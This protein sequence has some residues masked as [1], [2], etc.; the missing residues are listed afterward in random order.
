MGK[1]K[2]KHEATSVTFFSTKT[3]EARR[4]DAIYLFL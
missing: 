4:A 2:K 3:Y 1:I